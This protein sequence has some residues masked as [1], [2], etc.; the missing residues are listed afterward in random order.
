MEMYASEEIRFFFCFVRS[1]RFLFNYAIWLEA[2]K[3]MDGD[4]SRW[5]HQHIATSWA[6]NLAACNEYELALF[7]AET[8]SF[9]CF[10]FSGRNRMKLERK[11]IEPEEEEEEASDSVWW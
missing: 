9:S 10:F 8:F 4:V 3:A 7:M 11:K 2:R 5:K 6:E 1:S